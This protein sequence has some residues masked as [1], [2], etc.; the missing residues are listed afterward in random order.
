[1]VNKRLFL[2]LITLLLLALPLCSQAGTIKSIEQEI[3][4][5]KAG[6]LHK[7]APLTTSRVEAYLG[8]AMLASEAQ[9]DE[10]LAAALK[11]TEEMLAEAKVTAAGFQQQFHNLIELR[12]EANSVEEIVATSTQEETS[13]ASQQQLAEAERLLDQVIMTRERGELNKTQEHASAAEAA[14]REV[15]NANY[16]QLSVL[17]ARAI[18]KASSSGAKR[19]APVTYKA[20]NEQLAALRGYIDGFDS[21]PP[22][23]STEAYYLAIEAQLISQQVKLWRKNSSSFEEIVIREREFRQNLAR[24]L[25]METPES[26]L[27]VRHSPKELIAA[28]QGLKSTLEAERKARADD[29]VRLKI[30]FEEELQN[31]LSSQTDAQRSQ[32]TDMKEVFRAKLERETYEKK[33]QAQLRSQFNKGDADIFVNLDGSLLIR[34]IALQFP[35]GSSKIDP[36][37][38]DLLARLKLAL[39]A[40]ADR[41]VRIEGHTDDQGDVK[42]NQVLSLKRA[43]AVR[44]F[45]ISAGTDA[46]R[47]KALGYG[48]VRPIASN[49]FPQGRAMNRRI[50]IVIDA[51]K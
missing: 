26:V 49:E 32:I 2:P 1:M 29:A 25:D 27:L 22:S 50:D 35:S 46:G 7:Y 19:Y 10:E 16:S 37:H 41:T 6:G 9:K 17:T 23:H 44:D 34:M 18:S 20:A 33:R 21:T 8:A 4:A 47:L 42:P 45:L 14:Y 5:F 30:Q 11:R 48:E 28:V 38:N 12:R 43:E 39:E 40:Y 3:N 13:L 36:Q 15:L 24:A 31:R 51:A